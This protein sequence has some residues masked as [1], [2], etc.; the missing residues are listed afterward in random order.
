M[1]AIVW[2][3]RVFLLCLL[4][5]VELRAG[6]ECK[7][8]QNF[9]G[10]WVT[11]VHSHGFSLAQ[12]GLRFFF[13]KCLGEDGSWC[14]T[15]WSIRPIPDY[16]LLKIKQCACAFRFKPRSQHF[17]ARRL[18]IQNRIP[19]NKDENRTHLNTK[20]KLKRIAGNCAKGIKEF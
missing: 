4:F 5:F 19:A 2:S 11:H 3:V 12:Y 10:I 15:S 16:L 18:A 6:G 20:S 17:N 13:S 8:K 1:I 14:I 7:S 9:V